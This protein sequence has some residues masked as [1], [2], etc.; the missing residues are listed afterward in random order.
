MAVLVVAL[1]G[2][3][4][5]TPGQD[6]R[7][8]WRVPDG[9]VQWIPAASTMLPRYAVEGETPARVDR[10]PFGDPSPV[11]I[12]HRFRLSSP[13]AGPMAVVLPAVGGEAR[14]FVNGV[15]LRGGLA[16]SSPGLAWP[17]A[18][19][20]VWEIPRSH[21]HPG[22]NRVDI[23]VSGAPARALA[24]PIYLGPKAALEPAALRGAAVVD[25]ARRLVLALSVIALLL[26]LLA[27]AVRAPLY[28]L[29][30]GAAFAAT[31]TR[32]LLAEASG[33]PGPIWSVLDPLLLAAT[34]ICAGLALRG[35]VARGGP[36]R[37]IEAGLLTVVALS[38]AVGLAA[39]ANGMTVFAPAGP[40][41]LLVAVTWLFWI[42]ARAFPKL[43]ALPRQWQILS[44]LV[45]GLGFA[46][47]AITTA[48][49]GGLIAPGPTAGVDI[50]LAAGLSGLALL[51]SAA[52]AREI[53]VRVGHSLRT[54]LDQTRVIARQQAA[55]DVAAAA[56][57]QNTRRSAA[58]E[59][60]QRMARD[61]H[62]GIGG[63]LASLIAQ[64][65]LRKVSMDH[66]EQA[67]VGGLSELRLLVDSMDVVGETLADALASFLDRARQQTAAAGITLEW[68]QADGL[69]AEIREPQWILNL[70][71]LMQET[72]TNAIRHAGG[73]RI[74]VTI[75]SDGHLLTVLIENNGDAFDPETVKRGRGLANMAQRAADLGGVVTVG[76]IEGGR[77]TV[78]R[79]EAPL[80]L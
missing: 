8:P 10:L 52:G 30:I 60:R 71:R 24:A 69:G 1:A 44:G 16:A 62:D 45:A 13:A 53:V 22:E 20:R 36:A 39:G 27:V 76:P 26:N 70:Y 58:L 49:A 23:L 18:R 63:H 21:L 57:D 19:G 7:S 11:Q 80:P 12:S 17:S 51:A 33:L 55:L 6:Q 48:G 15:P 2:L 42:T 65:R 43:S 14:L 25:S 37:R 68:S 73:D 29:A 38:G 3:S 28:H 79:V 66:V 72:I 32:I 40:V 9:E 46:T 47:A 59:E 56:L 35:E 31:A 78:V 50:S 74:S 77:G 41:A 61:V 75:D 54:R 34:A 4:P 67:L 64:V 5:W